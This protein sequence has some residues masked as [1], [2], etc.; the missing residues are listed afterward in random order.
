M[1]AQHT[2]PDMEVP[3]PDMEVV[4]AEGLHIAYDRS[5]MKYPLFPD[6]PT[7]L[8]QQ[9]EPVRES[10]SHVCGLRKVTF[11]LIVASSALLTVVL[12][13]AVVA[14]VEISKHRNTQT[15]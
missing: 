3:Q 11:W 6:S 13:V 15:G 7:A 10:G 14:G 9:Q 1:A 5:N 8:P 12:V 2:Q 4:P